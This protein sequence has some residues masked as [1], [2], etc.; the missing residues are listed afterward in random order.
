MSSFE[1]KLAAIIWFVIITFWAWYLWDKRNK[2]K[3]DDD[4]KNM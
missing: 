1:I 2:S 3:K 4:Q